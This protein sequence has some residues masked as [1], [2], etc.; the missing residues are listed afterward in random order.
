MIEWQH[1][2]ISRRDLRNIKSLVSRMDGNCKG[3]GRFRPRHQSLAPRLFVVTFLWIVWLFP[4]TMTTHAF[5]LPSFRQRDLLF[6]T[7]QYCQ[8]LGMNCATPTDFEF[9]FQGFVQRGGLTDIHG[10]GWGLCFYQ[11]KGVRAFHD[12]EAACTSPIA[13]FLSSSYPIQTYNMMAHLRYATRGK[14][15]LAN[16][17]PFQREMV[18]RN[19]MR[20]FCEEL[21]RTSQDSLLGV[22]VVCAGDDFL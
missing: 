17:H 15:D 13:K 3:N 16:V 11:G 10:D 2:Y 6:L 1:I 5:L 19:D 18:S 22:F 20:M 7:V 4:S 14:V 21:T 8:L 12:T 9:S